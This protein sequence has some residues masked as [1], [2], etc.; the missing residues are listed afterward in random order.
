MPEAYTALQSDNRNFGTQIQ[1]LLD[2]I[3]RPDLQNQAIA[4]LQDSMRYFQRM[5]F[6]FSDLD[7][8]SGLTL[9]TWAASTIYPQ[10]STIQFTNSG[11]VYTAVATNA[12][13]SS[14]GGAPSFPT[15]LFAVP[16][17]ASGIFPPPTVGTAGTVVDNSS[18]TWATI[19]VFR[20]YFW[21]QLSTVYN[22][23][24]YV[25]P[26]DYVS[27]RRVEITIPNYRYKLIWMPYDEL[28]NWDV[29]RPPVSYSYP[30]YW[31]WF[32]QQIYLWPYPLGFY[33]IT[34]SYRAA[35]PLA[36]LAT[37]SNMWTTS[38]E[39]LVR[40]YARGRINRDVLKDEEAAQ[41][42][43][44]TADQEYKALRQQGVAQTVVSGIPLDQW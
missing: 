22:I 20:P 1:R 25:P 28:R 34:L 14:S 4:V 42:D 32:Q 30:M 33:P 8:S 9:P 2:D 40:A 27:P 26:I 11:T 21:A 38:A 5:P 15:T 6:F 43:F 17:N 18:I 16:S 7:N 41:T 12:G 39:A 13:T 10:G 29:V 36:Q 24:Q 44:A 19:A 23:N 35:P 37:D 31:A 3:N